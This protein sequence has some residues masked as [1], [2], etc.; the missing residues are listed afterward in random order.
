MEHLHRLR[1]ATVAAVHETAEQLGVAPRILA[2]W[3]EQDQLLANA[4]FLLG[5]RGP[6]TARRIEVETM[7]LGFLAF[8]KR[9]QLR[10][11]T[12]CGEVS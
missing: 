12:W 5:Q 4:M 10:P 11:R 1:K 8:L 3:L 2:E 7:L 6:L 9:A